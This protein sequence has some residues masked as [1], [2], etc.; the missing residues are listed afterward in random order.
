MPLAKPR[1]W[2]YPKEAETLSEGAGAMGTLP[3]VEAVGAFGLSS[4]AS[5]VS[6]PQ[7]S[8]DVV[9]VAMARLGWGGGHSG[10]RLGLL[11]I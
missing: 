6:R 1:G 4:P 2:N 8:S 10:Q 7:K 3:E 5:S 9:E 11:Q